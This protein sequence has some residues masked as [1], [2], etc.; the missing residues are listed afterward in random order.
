MYLY[1]YTQ[2][3]LSYTQVGMQNLLRAL[4]AH[5]VKEHLQVNDTKTKILVFGKRR[6][7]YKWQL[8]RKLL[9]QTNSHKYLGITFHGTW[10]VHLEC[11][12]LSAEASANDSYC[13][14]SGPSGKMVAPLIQLYKGKLF[15]QMLYG[16]PVWAF[17]S[18]TKLESV[19]H[20]FLTRAIG[21]PRFTPMAIV[22]YETSCYSVGTLAKK[23]AVLFLA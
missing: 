16:A 18:I 8:N 10:S 2:K 1:F 5:C 21:V 3:I 6:K 7:N 4:G 11:V 20:S 13:F 17:L 9:K 23:A 22:R 12:A 15:Y 14:S 19:Q